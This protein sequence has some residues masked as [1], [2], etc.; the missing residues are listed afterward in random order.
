MSI[1]FSYAEHAFS[2]S[3]SRLSVI[4]RYMYDD[5]TAPAERARWPGRID[6]GGD[7][8]AARLARLAGG[9]HSPA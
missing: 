8:Q 9:T 7:G 2:K 5:G 6:G 4:A 1:A 3:S